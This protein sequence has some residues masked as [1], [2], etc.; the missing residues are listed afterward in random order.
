MD[1]FLIMLCIPLLSN[2]LAWQQVV[3]QS[4]LLQFVMG[5]GLCVVVQ[6]VGGTIWF[7]TYHI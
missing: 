6:S 5:C 7:Y 2:G 4:L 3:W 1:I